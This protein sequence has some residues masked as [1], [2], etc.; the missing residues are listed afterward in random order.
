M[1][2]FF[3]R[4]KIYMDHAA[5]TQIDSDVL[6]AMN[7]V[8]TNNYFNP[9]GL[10]SEAI[11]AKKLILESRKK[12]AQLIGTTSD[13]IIF[14]RGG[15]ESCNLGIAGVVEKSRQ[16]KPHV[17]TSVIEHSAVLETLKD[18]EKKNKIE[19]TVVPVDKQGIVIVE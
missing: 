14:T 5:T 7:Q 19:L 15:T 2:D 9:G 4:N 3:L 1:F 10:Y 13:H 8:Y 6:R 18:L 11:I 12:V 16:E 17:I